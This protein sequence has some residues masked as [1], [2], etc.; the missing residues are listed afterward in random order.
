[1]KS[2]EEGR[3]EGSRG[4]LVWFGFPRIGSPISLSLYSRVSVSRTLGVCFLV[5]RVFDFEDLRC[6]Q[7]DTELL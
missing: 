3:K 5:T 2:F 1:M 6:W 7:V 4:G